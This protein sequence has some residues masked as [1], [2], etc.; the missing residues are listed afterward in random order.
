MPQ[1]A[2]SP[3]A[4]SNNAIAADAAR[5]VLIFTLRSGS[6]PARWSPGATFSLANSQRMMPG[7]PWNMGSSAAIQS[8]ISFSAAGNASIDVTILP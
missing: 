2:L 3:S 8:A 1:I 5:T 7:V 4:V 6:E